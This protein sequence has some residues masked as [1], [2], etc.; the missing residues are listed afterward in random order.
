MTLSDQRTYRFFLTN[1]I[2]SADD[3]QEAKG[4]CEQY[5]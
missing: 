1:A 5:A 2:Y 4:E 3:S